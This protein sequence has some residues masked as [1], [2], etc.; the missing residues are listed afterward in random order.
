MYPFLKFASVVIKARFREKLHFRDKSVLHCR[1][2]LTDIDM[3]MKPV[4]GRPQ[5]PVIAARNMN[6]RFVWVELVC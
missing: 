1:V 6:T 3:F 2:G 4:P 5:C